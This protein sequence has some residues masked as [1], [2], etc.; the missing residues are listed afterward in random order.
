MFVALVAIIFRTMSFCILYNAIVK[1]FV[2]V[3]C[4]KRDAKILYITVWVFYVHIIF[5]ILVCVCV[6]VCTSQLYAPR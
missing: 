4:E 1:Y 2:T 6:C 5:I 3:V